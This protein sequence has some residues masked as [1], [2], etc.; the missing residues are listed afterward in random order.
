MLFTRFR[1]GFDSGKADLY[2]YDLTT[3]SSTILLMDTS[4]NVSESGMSWNGNDLYFTSDRDQH[5]MIWRISVSGGE[6]ELAAYCDSLAL[7]HPSLAPDGTWLVCEAHL[8]NHDTG[9]RIIRYDLTSNSFLY[10]TDEDEDCRNPS[11]SPTD[12][13]IVFQRLMANPYGGNM[14]WELNVMDSNG[15]TMTKITSGSGDKTDPCYSPTGAWIA[16]ASEHEHTIP[17]IW[18]VREDGTDAQQF[19]SC[20]GFDAS[21]VWSANGEWL[22]FH[23]SESVNPDDHGETQIYRIAL[24]AEFN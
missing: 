16:Y 19:T 24:P 20:W 11:W 4:T 7:S 10:L 8:L 22:Y 6:P 12:N 5:D 21:P 18:M 1:D 17:V 23:T 14:Q 2:L 15:G 3:H 13:E 9:G